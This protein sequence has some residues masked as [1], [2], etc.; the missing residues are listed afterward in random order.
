MHVFNYVCRFVRGPE[1][2]YRKSIICSKMSTFSY[3]RLVL[4][5]FKRAVK[6]VGKTVWHLAPLVPSLIHYNIASHYISSTEFK[7]ISSYKKWQLALMVIQCRMTLCFCSSEP[8]Y[9]HKSEH[10]LPGKLATLV[11]SLRSQILMVASCVPVPRMSP[12]GWNCAAVR[13]ELL[14]GSLTCHEDTIR[15]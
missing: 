15:C 6:T 12:S 4:F 10:S 9:L 8:Y 2:S 14:L 1:D 11:L 7:P 3:K 13:A 5:V